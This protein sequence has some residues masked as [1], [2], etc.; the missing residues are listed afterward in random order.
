MAFYFLAF[1][2]LV[3][4]IGT[5]FFSVNFNIYFP[6]SIITLKVCHFHFPFL[7]FLV[8]LLQKSVSVAG[9]VLFRCVFIAHVSASYDRIIR[10]RPLKK[11]L[12]CLRRERLGVGGF[13]LQYLYFYILLTVQ[14]G[15]IRVNNQLDALFNV[16][17]SLLYK[18]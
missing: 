1:S 4:A 12:F 3:Q 17:I 9:R 11:I 13:Y 18:F 14:L 6:T 16:F 10:T 7:D 2:S 8:G 15:T 5:F